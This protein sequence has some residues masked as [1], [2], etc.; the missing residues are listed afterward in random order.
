MKENTAQRLARIMNERNL[1]QVDILKKSEKFQKELG[2]KLGKSALSQYV[3]GKSIPD[4]D[5]LVLLA[6][7][8]DVSE[9]WLMGYDT[10][11]QQTEPNKPS[12]DLS[13]LREKVVMFDGKPLSDDDVEKIEQIIRLSIEVMGDE[14]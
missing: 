9:A 7:T 5:K 6:K 3:S 1:R 8:L 11:E 4:Q 12:I 14:D 2:I 10:N 13:N